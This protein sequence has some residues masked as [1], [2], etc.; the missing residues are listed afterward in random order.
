MLAYCGS[1]ISPHLSR[2]KN[3]A[4]LCQNVPLARTGVQQYTAREVG[5][6]D[7]DELLDVVRP[8][9]QVFD[10]AALASF[11]AVPVTDNHPPSFITP[12][13][14]NWYSR[15]HCQNVHTGTLPDGT[16]AM[17][18]DIVVHD[19]SLIAKIENGLR[20]I[21][22]GYDCRYQA[23]PDGRYMQGEIRGNHIAVVPSARAGPH[24]KIQDARVEP[25]ANNSDIMQRLDRLIQILQHAID[26][27]TARPS[28][29]SLADECKSIAASARR[30]EELRDAGV[31][32]T[33]FH[34]ALI[35]SNAAYR[36]Y[37]EQQRR[38]EDFALAARK[39]GEEMA[40][41]F[42]PAA[43]KE[44]VTPVRAHDS[45]DGASWADSVNRL[46]RRLRDR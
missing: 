44:T 3:G 35:A 17:I 2:L 21:S 6:A 16:E 23:L 20:E 15:G 25:M 27:R 10:P 13:N 12:A 38:G 32:P 9:E 1:R 31:G 24:M 41:K 30:V 5:I 37:D 22:A 33:E 19:E 7:S 4:L 26:G 8:R 43:S 45:A 11:E 18:G 29:G 42:R 14:W 39:A 36:A 46:G 40:K 28:K 34:K